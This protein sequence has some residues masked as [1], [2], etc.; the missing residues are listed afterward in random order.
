MKSIKKTIQLTLSLL[1]II[2]I[3]GSSVA[4]VNVKAPEKSEEEEEKEHTKPDKEYNYRTVP[5]DPLNT[6]IYIL[7]NG[8]KVYMTVFEDKPRIQTYIAV[9][10]GSKNDPPETTGLAH[11]FE[12]MMFKGTT[13]FGTIN[14]EKEAPLIAKVDSLFEVYRKTD[15]K[16]KRKEIYSMIDSISYEASKYAIPNEYDKIMSTLGAKGT[17]AYTSM[18]QTVYVNNIPSNQMENFFTV[19]ADRFKNIV[20][21]GFHT[22]LETIYEEKN[23]TLTNDSRKMFTALLEG[24]FQKH[25]Y[26]TQTTIGTQED[27]KNPSMKNIREFHDKYYVPNNMAI[28]MSGD[29]DPDKAIRIIDEKFGDMERR[30]VPDY[31]YEKEDPIKK[32][33]KKE[34]YG[35]DAEELMLGFRFNGAGSQEAKMLRMMDMILTNG[36]AGLID[37]NLN[38]KQK[39]LNASSSPMIKEDYSVLMLS[40]EPKEEQTLDDVKNLLLNQIEKVKN[41]EFDKWLME[42]IVNDLKLRNKKKFEDNNSRA[43][44]YVQSFIRGVPWE[45][46]INRTKELENITKE[47]IVQLANENFSDNYVAVYKR[48]GEDTTIDKI[49]KHRTTDIEMNREEQSSFFAKIKEK[50]P[51]PIKPEF[52][53]YNS[54]I[55]KTSLDNGVK[56]LH[57][58]NTINNTFDLYYLFE[59]GKNND[60]KLPLAIDYLEFLGNEKYTAEEL[61][62]EFYK[63]GASYSVSTGTDQVYVHLSGLSENM[64]KAMQLFESWIN[65]PQPDQEALDKMINDKL[66]KRADAKQNPQQVFSRLAAFGIYGEENPVT[67]LLSEEKLKDLK[68]KELIQKLKSLKNYEHKVLYY[69]NKE[70]DEVKKLVKQNHKMGSELKSVKDIDFEQKDTKE[71][72]VYFVDFDTPQSMILMTSKSQKFNKDMISKI[73]LY[74]KYFGSGMKSIIFQ[75]IREKRSLAYTALSRYQVPA[76]YDKHHINLAFIATQYS[77]IDEAISNI[78]KLQNDMPKS[79]KSF[80]LAKESIIEKIRTE[81]VTQSDI[82]FNYLSAQKRNLDHD[83]RKDIFNDI[84]QFSLS[85]IKKFQE[86]YISDEPKT[87]MILGRKNELDK[88]MLKKY[89]EVKELK[90]EEIYGY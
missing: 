77:K 49:T 33:I 80:K 9:D 13:H 88:K 11:Y 67:N 85:D 31:D 58:P 69:G 46:Y 41:G 81:R 39:V 18:E 68:A 23:K 7:D 36:E 22:E 72:T 32:P 63:L 3:A 61:K 65:N 37:L 74:N 21:R 54:D 66:K 70:L 1:F 59:M 27:I 29:F 12:H 47:E 15:D 30:E 84:P 55:Q 6:R 52:L 76:E 56:I 28:A 51:E 83:I 62:K 20:L 10:A 4:Q 75:E 86:K 78:L 24:L 14:Y 2:S 44:A 50:Q 48:V 25:A 17:N 89:G 38:Q 40:G 71:N 26:G 43:R 79:E 87:I 90:M 16:E 57:T 53:D 42:A 73:R 45:N 34:V 19:E 35:P 8:L 82:L 60:K 64:N 5:G